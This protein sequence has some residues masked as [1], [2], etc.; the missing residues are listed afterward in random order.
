[1][2]AFEYLEEQFKHWIYQTAFFCMLEVLKE[3]KFPVHRRELFKKQTIY[4]RC[5]IIKNNFPN[6]SL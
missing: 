3:L 1:M 4:K 5:A 6:F 2:T